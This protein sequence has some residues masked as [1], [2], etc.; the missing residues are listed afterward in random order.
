[1][2]QGVYYGWKV[3][4]AL[5]V[6]LTFTSGLAFYNMSV[7]MNALVST[8]RY[9]VSVVSVGV[10]LFFV[11]SGAAG[12][13]AAP[14]LQ[15][16]DPRWTLAF[17]GVLGAVALLA[18][19]H[20]PNLA[21]L[22]GA[23][24]LFGVGHAC[25]AL[26]PATTLV[27]RW[28]SARRSV[29]LSITSTG[30]S[31]GGILL[32]P[33]AASL[34]TRLGLEASVPWLAAAWFLGI[35]PITALVVRGPRSGEEEPPL[36]NAK[37]PS[38]RQDEGWA[39]AEALR[40]RFFL[41]VTGA[42]VLC[43]GAQVGGIAHLF[44]MAA[45]RVDT[46][47][48]ASAVSAMATTS[49][50]GRFLG[51]WLITRMDTRRFA[52]ICLVLQAGAMTTLAQAHSAPFVLG[53]ALFFGATVG[54]LLMLQPLLLAEAFGV[55]EYPRIYSFSQLLST[56]GVAL[57]PALLGVLYDVTGGYAVPYLAAG[58]A[59]LAA[60]VAVMGSG[61]V[62]DPRGPRELAHAS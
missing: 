52:L 1:M 45:V 39:S 59:S 57:G 35:V 22:Y 58:A 53:A 7:L 24:M 38:L 56:L 23:L 5:F 25:S 48:G 60:W 34:I 37:S 47:A 61:A 13:I 18:L 6:M 11:A 50:L 32:T 42:W 44:N 20:A 30:L 14:L 19:G 17:G 26:V 8:G 40:S 28:F 49:I 27:A 41:A 21:A 2:Q 54:N 15:R 46:A 33:V 36:A 9:P 29:A 10:A 55:R 3:V 16:H 51:G 62:P 43:M 12:M 31:L 4:A